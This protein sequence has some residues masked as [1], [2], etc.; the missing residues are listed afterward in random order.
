ML[1]LPIA[2]P[3]LPLGATIVAE[4]VTVTVT[5]RGLVAAVT[6][7]TAPARA[8]AGSSVR[9]QLAGGTDGESYLITVDATG[10]A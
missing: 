4:T 3:A 6:P 2:F 1:W 9:V 7:L 10:S 8:V 5:A